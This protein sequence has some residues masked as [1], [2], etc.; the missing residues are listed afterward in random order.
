[1]VKNSRAVPARA[2]KDNDNLTPFELAYPESLRQNEKNYLPKNARDPILGIGLSGG[3]IRSATFCLGVF[4]GFASIRGLLARVSFL[5]TVSGGGYF[6]T[7]LGGIFMRQ[8]LNSKENYADNA[9]KILRQEISPEIVGYLRNNGNYLAPGGTADY[10]KIGAVCLRNLL[11]VN[12]VLAT[13]ALAILFFA[14]LLELLAAHWLNLSFFQQ[15]HADR[16]FI[17]SYWLAAPILVFLLFSVPLMINFW[18]IRENTELKYPR[19]CLG[20]FI[21]TG[22]LTPLIILFLPEFQPLPAKFLNFNYLILEYSGMLILISCIIY[23]WIKRK[24]FNDPFSRRKAR[25]KLE[26]LQAFS[27]KIFVALAVIGLIQSLGQTLYFAVGDISFGVISGLL[28]LLLSGKAEKFY[29]SVKS[30]F[31][32]KLLSWLPKPSLLAFFGI[33]V[34]FLWI[35]SMDIIVNAAV[36]RFSSPGVGNTANV[37]AWL[38]LSIPELIALFGF[39][40]CLLVSTCIGR[41]FK[42]INLCSLNY[43]YKSRLE[44]AYLDASLSLDKNARSTKLPFYYGKGKAPVHLFNVTVNETVDGTTRSISRDRNGI[45]MAVGPC[46]ISLGVKHHLTFRGW[47]KKDLATTRKTFPASEKYHRVFK[48]L[49][50]ADWAPEWLGASA[51]ASISGAAM[52][53]GM[54]K[55]GDCLKS[56]VLTLGNVRLGYWWDSDVRPI[57]PKDPEHSIKWVKYVHRQL[58]AGFRRIAERFEIQRKLWAEFSC[59]FRGS[60]ESRWYLSDGGHFENLGGYE[61]IRRRLPLIVLVDAEQDEDFEF[62]GL[63]CLIRKARMDFGAEIEF[64]DNDMLADPASIDKNKIPGKLLP[65][66]IQLKHL[67]DVFGQLDSLKPQTPRNSSGRHAALGCITYTNARKGEPESSLLI[68]LKASMTGDEPLDLL[69]YK[70]ENAAF[71]HQSTQDQFFDEAQWESYRKLGEHAGTPPAGIIRQLIPDIK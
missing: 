67:P 61:L 60:A 16:S 9:E 51:W 17:F 47:D 54:G 58:N 65:R 43:F 64:F 15:Y 57:P 69:A 66:F 27:L 26:N 36:W 7:F 68:Y 62:G 1:M 50:N 34:P 63:S 39:F 49:D 24:T 19:H 44:Q 41:D 32:S 33:L 6:G 70:A 38:P 21:I 12:F 53:P 28:A 3:G 20:L 46:G 42:F 2:G 37:T 31:S 18:L 71:P 8:K 23:Y 13:A 30:C 56:A 14:E 22:I 52:S 45:G 29:N 11:A 4:Q 59:T 55:H 48:G 25:E 5:S 10:M 40:F 35:L